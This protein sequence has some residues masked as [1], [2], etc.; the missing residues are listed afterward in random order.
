[1]DVLN[2]SYLVTPPS[3]VDRE[4]VNEDGEVSQDRPS[5]LTTVA[6]LPHVAYI[7]LT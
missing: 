3:L 6:S 1:V 7:A 4:Q 5:I 2:Q